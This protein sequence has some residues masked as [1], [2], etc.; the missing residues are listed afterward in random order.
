MKV[1]SV[2]VLLA[3][4]SISSNV[5]AQNTTGNRNAKCD[6]VVVRDKSHPVWKALDAQYVKVER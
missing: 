3:L 5:T 6:E 2:V 4:C 1:I